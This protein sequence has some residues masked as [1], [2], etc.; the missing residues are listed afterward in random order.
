[1]TTEDAVATRPLPSDAEPRGAMSSATASRALVAGLLGLLAV[2]LVGANRTAPVEAR[3][4]QRVE[5]VSLIEAEQA[6]NAQL[7]ARVEE[8]SA[9]LAALERMGSGGDA[10]AALSGDVDALAAPAGLTPVRGPGVVATLKDSSKAPTS[11]DDYN[12]FVIHE[13]DLQAVINA[14]W[15]GGAEAMSVNGNRILTTTAIRCVGNVL[16]LHGSTYSPPYVIEAV[17]DAAELRSALDRDPA[18]DRFVDAVGRF[19][20]GYSVEE[21][22]ELLLPGYEGVPTMQHARPVEPGPVS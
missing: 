3:L 7:A 18:V 2:V 19:S 17:G 9:E 8:L 6:R 11:A 5:L 10:V 14:L 15:A 4:G 21:A 22:A 13:Q 16:L 1:V 20:L 12:D